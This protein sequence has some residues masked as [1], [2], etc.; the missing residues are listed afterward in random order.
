MTTMPEQQD[1]ESSADSPTTSRRFGKP[2]IFNM[3]F[4]RR[5]TSNEYGR[6]SDG[7]E[8]SDG[9]TVK[10]RLLSAWNNV[11]FGK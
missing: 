9:D 6:K 11:K 4:Y 5:Q 7:N 2:R 3:N 1:E 10:S 8:R